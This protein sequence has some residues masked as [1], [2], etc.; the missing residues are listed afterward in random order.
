MRNFIK[1][2]SGLCLLCVLCGVSM[3]C[4]DGDWDPVTDYKLWN[5]TIELG[6]TIHIQELKGVYYDAIQNSSFTK[7]EDDLQ[8]R[9]V[10]VVNDEGGNISQQIIVKDFTLDTDD[11]YIII[12]V[13]ETSMFSYVKPGQRILMNLKG[14]YIGGYGKNAQIGYPSKSATSGAERIGRMT[15]QDWRSHV[16]LEGEP[17]QRLIPEPVEFDP[18]WDKDDYSDHLIYVDGSFTEAD[19]TATLAPTDMADAG[20]AVNRTFKMTNGKTVDIRTSTYSDF[21]NMVMPKGTVRVYGVVIRYNNTW[22]IQMRTADDLVTN[23]AN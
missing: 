5:D 3:S 21:G 17:D 6:N 1:Y 9:G 13:S 7:I 19:G 12:G 18:N 10:V 20:N 2:L 14:L 16:C 22:Q 15:I 23:P 11:G 8:L 4:Q